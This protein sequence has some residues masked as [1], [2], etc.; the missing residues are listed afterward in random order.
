MRV[1]AIGAHFDDVELGCGGTVAKHTRD[2]DEVVIYV[3][4]KSGFADSDQK[5][6]RT[7]EEALAEGREAAKVLGVET[8]IHGD[9]KTNQLEFSQL[10]V[11]NL[12]RAIESHRP[13]IIYTHWD[14]DVHYDH[15]AVGRATLTAGRHVP[16][17]LMYRSNYYDSPRPFLGNYYVDISETIGQKRDAIRVHRSEYERIGEKWIDFFLTQNRNDGQKVHVEYAEAFQVV[18]YLV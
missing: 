12:L 3:A 4:T 11:E 15:Q 2:G 18:K 1:L 10:F 8:V 14:G 13:E 7:D 9:F 5:V 17:I 6:I 16:R